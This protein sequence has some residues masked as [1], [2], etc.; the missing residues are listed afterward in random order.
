MERDLA[1]IQAKLDALDE[2]AE[3]IAVT[4]PEE[5]VVIK[6]RTNRLRE[7]WEQLTA[8][9]KVDD[10]IQYSFLQKFKIIFL[11]NVI[12]SFLKMCIIL[13]FC[14]LSIHFRFLIVVSIINF[15]L[16]NHDR[17]MYHVFQ[18]VDKFINV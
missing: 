5:A 17:I 11:I 16:N 2:E 3:K 18:D 12:Y 15:F 10:P 8:M 13:Y 6:Q 14:S 1:A 9:L 7:V 4:H